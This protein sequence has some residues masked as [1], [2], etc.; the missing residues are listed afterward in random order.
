MVEFVGLSGPIN[1]D[2]SGLRTQF[3]MDLMELQMKGLVSNN[4]A[5]FL[6]IILTLTGKGWVLEQS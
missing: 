3:T 5:N 2:T 6:L 1:F 4:Y